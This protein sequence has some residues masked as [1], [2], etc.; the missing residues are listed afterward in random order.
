MKKA[1][2]VISFGTTYENTRKLTIDKIEEKIRNEFKDYEIRRAFTSYKIIEVLKKRDNIIVDTPDTAL[3]KLKQDGY[4]EI[5]IQPLHI[6]PGSEYEFVKRIVEK[7]SEEFKKIKLGRPVLYYKGMPEN[8]PDDYAIMIDSIK[9]II[10]KEKLVI[11]MGHGSNHSSNACYS[12]LQLVLR[13][14]GFHN[15]FIA[16]VEG[17][18]NIDDVLG[19]V[20]GYSSKEVTLIPLMLVAGNHALIDMAGED[21]DSF[22][23][24]LIKHGFEV[25][26]YMHGLGEIEKFQQIYIEHIKDT[27]KERYEGELK[28]EK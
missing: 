21:E 13:D 7:Y 3:E 24:V 23:N 26:P 19:Y 16:N 11:L 8:F 9:D 28:G 12:C 18:P 1:I 10:P 17:Y 2:L 25:T 5:I 15:A 27:I 14:R 22:K 20:K 4:E 6:I